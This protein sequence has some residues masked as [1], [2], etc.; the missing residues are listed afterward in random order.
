MKKT[1][2][3]MLA[4]IATAPMVL[5]QTQPR[6]ELSAREVIAKLE[7]AGYTAIDEI[8]KDD[9]V[10]EVEATNPSGQRVEIHIDPRT[11]EILREKS[12]WWD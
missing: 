6:T 7:E 2:L 8:D 10:W 1:L 9:G 12:E 3:A 11:G 4:L 5:A